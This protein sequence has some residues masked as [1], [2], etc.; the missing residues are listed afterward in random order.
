MPQFYLIPK[1]LA[2]KAPVLVSIAQWLEALAFRFIFWIMRKLSLQRA[3]QLSAFAFGLVGPY[4]DKARKAKINLATAFPDT[5]EQWRVQT[6]RQIFRSLGVSAA[7]LIKLE[8]I[9]DQRDQRLEYVIHPQARELMACKGAA[10]FVTAHVGPWQI[11]PFASKNFGITT[12]TIYAPESNAIVAKL[13]LDLRKSFGEKLI[14]SDAGARPLIK[15]LRAG[16]S[17]NMA[18]DTRP[19]SGKMVPF[20]GRDALTS[21]SAARLAL[22][23]GAALVPG[24]AERL[25][26]G[27]F[28]ITM[29]DPIICPNPD[30]P[31][32]E[33]ALALT[34]LI[35]RHFEDWIREDPGQ[36][37]C[38]KRRW[39]KAH[40]L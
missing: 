1:K 20:F 23:T 16:R 36:W 7:E 2:R 8:Q 37:I 28:R 15:E 12:S 38:L 24:R 26:G 14:A 4:G 3:S 25:P 40:K 11:S 5:S 30:A 19:D 27:R 10:V 39:P 31:I 9:W 29:Y 32:D 22:R 17:I 34:E 21:T 6:I 13:M 18:I 35:Y 33:Q